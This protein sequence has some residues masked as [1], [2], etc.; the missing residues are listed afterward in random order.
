[1][2]YAISFFPEP[3]TSGETAKGWEGAEIF[4]AE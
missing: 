1:V 2:G 4:A 3:G